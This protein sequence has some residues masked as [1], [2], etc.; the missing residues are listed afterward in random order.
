MKGIRNIFVTLLVALLAPMAANADLIDF[1]DLSAADGSY[2]PQGYKGFAWLGDSDE[3][4]WV[5]NAAEPLADLGGRDDYCYA[6]DNCAWSN[7]GAG[8]ELSDGLFAINSLWIYSRA[9]DN[10]IDFSGLFGGAETF[11]LSV[12]VLADTWTQVF[13]GFSG[14]DT[15]NFDSTI[16]ANLMV[17]NITTVPEPGTLALL[18]I[19]LFGMAASRI[20][21]KV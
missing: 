6:G 11:S 2:I 18:G 7:G 3:F 9:T 21:N 20:R 13:L 10:T 8:L 1:E 12:D 15:L 16:E 5:N 4:S 14:I 17:D 19:G